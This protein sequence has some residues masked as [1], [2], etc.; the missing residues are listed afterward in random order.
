MDIKDRVGLYAK[1]WDDKQLQIW[2][3]KVRAMKLVETGRFVQSFKAAITGQ[4]S[5][6]PTMELTFLRYGIYQA[7]GVG[8]FYSHDNG[9]DLRFLD[10]E[11][12][13]GNKLDVPRKR[14]PKWGGGETS[15][16]P[17]ERRDWYSAKLYTSTR[18]LVEDM[19]GI[20]GDQ[21]AH[22]ICEA[23]M[24]ERNVP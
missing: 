3:E 12:R 14:G 21:A 18:A 2:E 9:G 22:V 11:Y 17:R 24:D 13:R 10:P 8:N 4:F 19:A 6:Q 7:R 1:A 15:G 5:G 16:N 23:L 20:F